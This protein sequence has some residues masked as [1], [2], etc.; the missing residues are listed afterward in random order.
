MKRYFQAHGYQIDCA[1]E[2]EEAEALITHTDY[3]CVIVDL[4]LTEARATDGLEVITTLRRDHPDTPVIVLTA[5]GSP[6]TEAEARRL[7]AAAFV[8]KPRPMADVAALVERLVA[9]A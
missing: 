1:R 7:G 5:F 8:R 4:S 3:A 6:A 9:S 2:R